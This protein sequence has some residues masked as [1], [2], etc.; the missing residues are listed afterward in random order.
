MRKFLI[1]S[2]LICFFTILFADIYKDELKKTEKDKKMVAI[3][4]KRL[5]TD[6]KDCENPSGKNLDKSVVTELEIYCAARES[7]KS[8][9]PEIKRLLSEYESVFK[10]YSETCRKIDDDGKYE[11]CADLDQKMSA[12]AEALNNEKENF[13]NDIDMLENSA[14]KAKELN[15]R[16]SESNKQ[17][18]IRTVSNNLQA[19]KELVEAM[20]KGLENDR[21]AFQNSK[22]QLNQALKNNSGETAAKGKIF[23]EGLNK[24][25]LQN[26]ALINLCSSMLNTINAAKNVCVAK[27]DLKKCQDSEKK[28]ENLFND[29]NEKLSIYKNEKNDILAMESEYHKAGMGDILAKMENAKKMT[30]TYIQNLKS[31]NDYLKQQV[32]MSKNNTEI[33]KSRNNKKLL[34]TYLGYVA[35]MKELEKESSEFIKIYEENLSKIDSFTNSC[36]NG[37]SEFTLECRIEG[38]KIVESINETEPK[39]IKY[40]DR[41]NKLNKDL[42]DFYKKFQ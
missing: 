30:A 22:K 26:G 4:E 33:V 23:L 38:D 42:A 34:D 16:N 11:K 25:L 27:T 20:K 17:D 10:E 5:A 7:L 2:V 29:G 19:K 18:F 3:I 1:F 40:G 15:S 6:E 32:E 31:Q 41:F 13:N 24:N 35:T 39:V 21:S 37:K 9:I 12:S 28:L 14:A 8:R 36:V